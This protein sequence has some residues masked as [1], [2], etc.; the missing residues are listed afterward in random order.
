[1]KIVKIILI[2]VGLALF[3]YG[4]IGSINLIRTKYIWK[5]IKINGTKIDYQIVEI[6]CESGTI[7]CQKDNNTISKDIGEYCTIFEVGQTISLINSN[8][9]PDKYIFKNDNISTFQIAMSILISL[10]GL[11][12]IIIFKSIDKIKSAYNTSWKE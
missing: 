7:S 3:I 12:P 2:Y 5:N 4:V 1:M 8:K 9:Y 6:D 11:I 10:I